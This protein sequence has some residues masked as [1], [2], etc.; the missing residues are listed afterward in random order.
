MV[1]GKAWCFA[2]AA[3]LCG[4]VGAFGA[5]RLDVGSVTGKAER[6]ENKRFESKRFDRRMNKN[7]MNKSFPIEK[8]EKHFSPLGQKR[9]PVGMD[10]RW[11][12]RSEFEADVRDERE[13][14]RW[15]ERMSRWNERMADLRREARIDTGDQANGFEDAQRFSWALMQRP[16]FESLRDKLSL[17]ELNRYQFRRNRSTETVPVKKP[18]SGE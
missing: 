18:D 9:A 11:G 17:S 13:M 3:A 10:D 14:A 7:F 5:P 4:V 1:Q 16:D 8:W 6:I 15:N 2:G 12:R